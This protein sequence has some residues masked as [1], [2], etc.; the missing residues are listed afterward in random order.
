MSIP[1]LDSP[2]DREIIKANRLGFAGFVLDRGVGRLLGQNGE[3]RLRPQAF[4]LL[5]VLLDAAP[6]ILS[7][8]ELL[9][10]AWGVEHLSPASVKQ[11]VSEI[12]QALGD[13]PARPS[14]IETV[15]RR[16]YR[17]IA[18]VKPVVRTPDLS[19]R[20]I[21][22]VPRRRRMGFLAAALAFAT[23]SLGVASRLK[24]P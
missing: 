5:E 20:P 8:D 7:Q 18:P 1:S 10:Q 22:S 21:T 2:P 16:G 14:I 4:R 15:H 13:D 6:R 17:V 23:L 12:R 11:A 19:T 9:D 24:R 3:I